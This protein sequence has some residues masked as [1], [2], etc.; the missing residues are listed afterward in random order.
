ML[1]K[2][3]R[4]AEARASFADMAAHAGDPG[5][6]ALAVG[7]FVACGFA[8]DP[9]MRARLSAWTVMGEERVSR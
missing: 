3:S 9:I 6:G 4:R 2:A 8:I 5:S 7:G 1:A